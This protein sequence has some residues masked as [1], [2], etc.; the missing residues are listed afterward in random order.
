MIT[1]RN[2]ADNALGYGFDGA[3]ELSLLTVGDVRVLDDFLVHR[4]LTDGDGAVFEN[5]SLGK[6]LCIPRG[7]LLDASI[8]SVFGFILF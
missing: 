6:Y 7:R 1:I 4:A 8:N 2:H 5:I 3:G